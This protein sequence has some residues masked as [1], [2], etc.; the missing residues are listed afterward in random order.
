MVTR[1]GMLLAGVIDLKAY[2]L[3]NCMNSLLEILQPSKIEEK[4]EKGTTT[5]T[6][7]LDES[8]EHTAVE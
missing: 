4:V 5:K 6:S 7:T 8:S 1:I 2:N 3:V